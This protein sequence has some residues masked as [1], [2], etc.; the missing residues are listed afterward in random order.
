MNDATLPNEGV[1]VEIHSAETPTVIPTE[2][3]PAPAADERPAQETARDAQERRAV[4]RV[5]AL[6]QR[7]A[8]PAGTE[9]PT[10]APATEETAGRPRDERGRFAPK[11]AEP[12]TETAPPAQTPAQ[13]EEPRY[14]VKVDGRELELPISDILK[15][16][17][18]EAASR[19][20][21]DEAAQLRRE[22]EALRAQAPQPPTETTPAEPEVFDPMVKIRTADGAT[23]ERPYSD[24]MAYGTPEEI[25]QAET[26]KYNLLREQFSRPAAAAGLA[27]DQIMQVI[28][29]SQVRAN[30]EATLQKFLGEYPAIVNDPDLATIAVAKATRLMTDDLV[31]L[32]PEYGPQI[33]RLPPQVIADR[34]AQARFAGFSVRSVEQIFGAAAQ[35]TAQRFGAVPAT[36]KPPAKTLEERTA[37]KASAPQPA[38]GANAR[39]APTSD[40][41]ARKTRSDIIREE[42]R[43]RGFGRT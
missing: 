36:G 41:P 18:L 27:P 24:V 16:Y 6:R 40:A 20:R 31:N 11:D 3:T 26:Q 9:P 7:Q 22:A 10:E 21:L 42:Q 1:S 17:Q 37:A 30:E 23:Y 2:S 19:K 38:Q 13:T 4:E 28:R 15:G 34:H 39:Q 33:Q 8:E 12:Q 14:K 35:E 43:A 29:Y 32:V 25:R 5:R